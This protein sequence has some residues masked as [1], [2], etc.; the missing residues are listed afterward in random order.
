MVEDSSSDARLV[1]RELERAGHK[2][3]CERVEDESG[4]RDALG[5]KRWD[6][7]ICDWSMPRFSGPAAL[8]VIK[9]VKLDIPF[10]IVSGT[11][12][13]DQAV[14]AMRAGAHDY[15]LKDRL[16]R[17]APAVERELREHAEREAR[18]RAEESLRLSEARFA[19]L[20]ESGIVGICIAD[21]CG[22]MYDANDAYLKAIGYSRDDL[23][24][25]LAGWAKITPPEW[26]SGDELAVARLR[27]QGVAPPWEK[28]FI[29]KDGTRVPVLLGV[30]MLDYPNCVAFLVDLTERKRAEAA[31]RQSEERLLQSQKMEAIGS[32][33]GGIA[34]DFNNL[35]TVILSYSGMLADDLKPGDPMRSDIEEI[36]MAGRRAADLTRQLLA[37]SRQQ[38]L[39]P[40]AVNLNEVVAKMEKMLR[41]LIGEDIELLAIGPPDLGLVMVDPGQIEQ[42]VMNL[43]VNARDAMPNGGK[44]TIETTPVD[45]D[46][47]FASDHVGATPGPHIMLAVTD[48]GTGMDKATQA[49]MFEPFFTTKEMGKGTGLGLSTVFGIVKQSSGSIWVYSEPGNGTAFKIYFP[50]VT[51]FTASGRAAAESL[52]PA[53]VRGSETI[54]LVEDEPQVRNLV[55]SILRRHGYQV[56]EAQNGGDALL[57]CEQHPETIQLLLTDVVMPKMS[58][59]QLAERLKSIRPEMKVLYMSGYT[60]NSIIHHGVLDANVGFIQKPITPETLTR[61]MRSV[62][63][64]VTLTAR[65]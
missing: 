63:S 60:D 18:R 36:L 47:S 11:V 8:T 37:F 51:E 15:V 44:L 62:L 10:I 2:L 55:R 31:L 27:E 38:V 20:S 34:H 42:V 57:L 59:P 32:L 40:Q 6:I 22:T 24:A 21:V 41:R 23:I 49:R 64:A 29:R 4:L 58:G 9:D 39:Q 3:F 13:E 14:E 46:E 25:G 61:K 56:L 5:R 30:A 53:D 17:L 43:A 48:S 54:L 7:V 1:T 35:L 16:A 12:G 28:E 19:R 26:R 52:A 45:L 65:R 50:L 33:T